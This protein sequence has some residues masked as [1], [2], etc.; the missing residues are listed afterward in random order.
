MPSTSESRVS[1]S[2][3]SVP[4]LPLLYLWKVEEGGQPSNARCSET[5]SPQAAAI[6]KKVRKAG[7]D[8]RLR[9]SGSGLIAAGTGFHG[10]ILSRLSISGYYYPDMDR[11][12]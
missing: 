10:A 11:S 2:K 5:V 6:G 1:V 12:T 9:A 3:D 7:A 4:G 8:S